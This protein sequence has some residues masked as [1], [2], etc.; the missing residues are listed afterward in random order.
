LLGILIPPKKL[1]PKKRAA[2][3]LD[4]RTKA[5]RKRMKKNESGKEQ[6]KRMGRAM[7]IVEKH[8]GMQK[9]N[10]REILARL[11]E[12]GKLS[13]PCTWFSKS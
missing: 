13:E 11:V 8:F 4:P 10:K 1:V 9:A 7:G 2:G 6:T 3:S 12:E 5:E